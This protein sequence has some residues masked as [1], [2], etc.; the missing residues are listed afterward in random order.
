MLDLAITAS[1]VMLSIAIALTGWRLVFGPSAADRV[2]ALDTMYV[3]AVAL[4]IA[5]GVKLH[6]AIFFEAA[7]LIALMGFIG[8]IA[9]AR[10]LMRRRI[11]GRDE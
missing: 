8:T 3:I 10:F 4:I 11:T 7:L 6:E 9:L 5:L 2:L 1:F